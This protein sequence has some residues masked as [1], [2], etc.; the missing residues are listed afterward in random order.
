MKVEAAELQALAEAEV[1]RLREV[2]WK[3]ADF[4]EALKVELETERTEEADKIEAEIEAAAHEIEVEEIAAEQDAYLD[5]L[6]ESKRWPCRVEP[7]GKMDHT[8]MLHERVE[9]LDGV[10]G[11]VKAVYTNGV[12][13]RFE[14]GACYTVRPDQVKS[15]AQVLQ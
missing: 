3:P 14:T 1:V 8:L 13:V 4:A 7:F 11:T 9:R 2:G 10:K 6:P 5:E 12:L 15:V